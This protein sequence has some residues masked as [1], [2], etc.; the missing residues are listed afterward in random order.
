MN[1]SSTGGY[2]SSLLPPPLHAST[3]LSKEDMEYL[4]LNNPKLLGLKKMYAS[5]ESFNNLHSQWDEEFCKQQIFLP[6]FRGDNAYI[7]QVRNNNSIEKYNLTTEYLLSIDKLG[8]FQKT[9]E[10]GSFGAFTYK[11][12]SGLVV[13]RDL[14]DSVCE[15]YF[16]ENI[17][18][19]ST[20]A[21]IKILDI[22]AGY[23]RLGHRSIEC[24]SG[25]TSYVCTDAVAESTFLCDFYT[26]FRGVTPKC[27][28]TPIYNIENSIA[29]NKPDLALNIHSFSE[30]TLDSIE[31]WLSLL[32]SNEVRYLMIA[33]NNFNNN[34]GKFLISLEKNLSHIN[35]EKSIAK[36]GYR[37]IAK[38]PKFLDVAVQ[39]NG[40]SPTY[41][42][43]YELY[44]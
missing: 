29:K 20:L 32:A 19:L 8:L 42:Y 30:C 27:E 40:I 5:Y 44:P 25:I 13:S 16:L 14:L 36:Y 43:L 39:T 12:D 33:P 17:L 23:G 34:D 22:G 7:W 28:T 11:S 41:Y 1:N 26:R 37:L 4:N 15:L 21:D 24:F 6:Y 18:S 31:L 35:Y 3:L 38:T 9:F 10:D 2:L